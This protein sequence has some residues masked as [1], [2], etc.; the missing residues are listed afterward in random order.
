MTPY[1]KKQI[2]RGFILQSGLAWGR[3]GLFVLI[4]ELR[5][6]RVNIREHWEIVRLR[7]ALPGNRGA[8]GFPG[9]GSG[10]G[11]GWHFLGPECSQRL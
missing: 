7:F 2:E 3:W 4:T 9:S 6:R 1:L 8:G 10:A 11:M 5:N